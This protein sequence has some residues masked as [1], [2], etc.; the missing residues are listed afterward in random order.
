ME[1]YSAHDIFEYKDTPMKQIY[2]QLDEGWVPMFKGQEA[3]D[4]ALMRETIKHH[5]T[6]E[7]PAT[8]RVYPMP[9]EHPTGMGYHKDARETS[10]F[11]HHTLHRIN[12]ILAKAYLGA[13]VSDHLDRVQDN[14]DF[15]YG[16]NAYHRSRDSKSRQHD[17]YGIRYSG[18]QARHGGVLALDDEDYDY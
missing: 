13:P 8:D 16:A 15:V 7:F 3:P 5:D 9:E 4:F 14:S 18:Q 10:H 2:R 6:T 12:P 17:L 11:V 1:S